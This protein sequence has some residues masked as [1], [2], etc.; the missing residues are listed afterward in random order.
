[1][2]FINIRELSTGTSLVYTD[3]RHRI[4]FG[5]DE[6]GCGGLECGRLIETSTPARIERKH[7]PQPFVV[8]LTGRTGR[9]GL[10][11][12]TRTIRSFCFR[13]LCA[14]VPGSVLN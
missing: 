1:M 4:L 12:P 7:C 11:C 9:T 2:K 6:E 5:M 3:S 14:G 10:T 8:P 13:F